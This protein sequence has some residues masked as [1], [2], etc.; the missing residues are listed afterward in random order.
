MVG[1]VVTKHILEQCK[2]Q[3]A[4]MC[5]KWLIDTFLSPEDLQMCMRIVPH[6]HLK[7]KIKKIKKKTGGK[8]LVFEIM[9]ASVV[10]YHDCN[11]EE[12]NRRKK[13]R[14]DGKQLY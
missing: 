11:R 7:L 6:A 5:Q 12:E 3:E 10:T 13:K 8:E 4:V 1:Y 9:C 2:N 14:K